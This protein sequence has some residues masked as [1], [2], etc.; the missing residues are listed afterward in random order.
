[1]QLRALVLAPLLLLAPRLVGAYRGRLFTRIQ[2]AAVGSAAA[3]EAD[4]ESGKAG[5][6]AL[7]AA[8]VTE[9]MDGKSPGVHDALNLLHRKMDLGTAVQQLDGKLPEDVASLVHM[10]AEQGTKTHG[11][12]DENSMAKARK[13]LNGMMYKAWFEL[14]D[15]IFECMEFRDRNRGTYTQ[16]VADLARLGSTL[17]ELNQ[18]RI[19]ASEC[20]TQQENLRIETEGVLEKTRQTYNAIF[21]ENSRDLTIKT[22]D[23][24]VFDF[25]LNATHCDHL[26]DLALL[27]TRGEKPQV[28]VCRTKNGMELN[29]ANPVLQAK[30]ERMM[31][32]GA[33]LELRAALGQMGASFLELGSASKAGSAVTEPT[34]TTAFPQ[35]PGVD[36]LMVPEEPHPEGQ[37]KKC[38]DGTPN[39]GLLHDLMS[40]EWGKF[41]DSFDELTARMDANKVRYDEETRNLNDQL[42]VIADEKRKCMEIHTA[43]I[44]DI[45]ADTEEKNEKDEQHRELTEDFDMQC[46]IFRHKIQEILH[47]K[48]CA[49]R[50]VRNALLTSST[51]SP[52]S[53]ISDCDFTDWVSKTGQC[54]NDDGVAIT[55]DDTCPKPNPYECGGFET[56]KRD[57]VV[58]PNQYGMVCPQLERKKKCGQ[59]KCEVNCV[60]SLWSGWSG[61]TKECESGVRERTRSIMV[62]P[63]NGGRVCD[64]V[65]EPEDCN[66]FTCDRDCTLSDWTAWEPCSMACGGGTTKRVKKVL[67]PIRGQGKC[68]RPD[69]VKR[70]QYQECNTEECGPDIICIAKQDLIITLDASGSLKENGFRILR[71]FAANLTKRY[72]PRYF[73]SEAVKMGLVLFGNGELQSQPDGTTT[74]SP[75]IPVQPLTFDVGS[76]TTTIMEQTWQRGFTN[77][78]QA[79]TAADTLLSQGGRE[80]AQSAILVLSDG[81]YTMKY[82]TAEKAQELK[83]KNIMLYMAPVLDFEDEGLKDL[84]DWASQPWETNYE[85]IPG[86]AKLEYSG[87]IFI[88]KLLVK[89]CPDSLSPA[90]MITTDETRQ[91]M[92]IKETGYP[93][94]ECGTYV[95]H[96]K[97]RGIDQCAAIARERNEKAFSYGKLEA[98]DGCYTE[99]IDVTQQYWNENLPDRKNPPLPCTDGRWDYALYDT[100]I[101]N[102]ETF[103]YVGVST[104]G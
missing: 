27:Q 31:S 98:K 6:E 17:A 20:Q 89:F 91:Y 26:G 57:V 95:Y 55:C 51:V 97:V 8:L 50:K 86:L 71:N 34:T 103:E 80:E 35:Y 3:V 76:V 14:D 43:A 47:T 60:M 1:M 74:I 81:R 5:A 12:F 21:T 59:K 96:G 62:K 9:V 104:F 64:T 92:L 73:G 44:S 49:V 16:V 93:S 82:Q 79:L 36:E 84:K 69:S 24:A 56:M 72:E 83:D 63:K 11:T 4:S 39:C 65:Q 68:P 48:I 40:L 45:N 25:I 102:P 66:T 54:F 19:W 90:E 77:M 29:F 28:Q 18:K 85:R 15:V 22:N 38:V 101:L 7:A 13:I 42:S 32:P 87:D 33:R 2:G 67:V 58:A 41:R 37:W 10:T 78:A 23:L 52:P 53:K 94:R 30:V 75:A 61:C 100:Y 99:A 88:Q 46:A 70:M